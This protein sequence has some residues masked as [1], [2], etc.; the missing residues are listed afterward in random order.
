MPGFCPPLAK[1][2]STGTAIYLRHLLRWTQQKANT[3]GHTCLRTSWAAQPRDE[4]P[5]TIVRRSIDKA[6]CPYEYEQEQTRGRTPTRL[7]AR[8]LA[9]KSPTGALK[10]PPIQDSGHGGE[11][12]V[13]RKKTLETR[14]TEAESD[15]ARPDCG[16][17]VAVCAVRLLF[18]PSLPS[19]P[20]TSVS[21]VFFCFLAIASRRVRIPP[22]QRDD[23]NALLAAAI[24]RLGTDQT[25]RIEQYDSTRSWHAHFRRSPTID[26]ADIVVQLQSLQDAELL[27]YRPSGHRI[28]LLP[29]FLLAASPYAGTLHPSL[30]ASPQVQPSR[31]VGRGHAFRVIC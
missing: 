20:R 25:D 23:R 1:V 31:P 26:K 18:S 11:R 24:G 14:G 4:L 30:A 17:M 5:H 9:W 13:A 6:V 16:S 19:K 22:S 28:P 29:R 21:I 12:T 10:G 8:L 15:S 2:A 27:R 7:A 3:L